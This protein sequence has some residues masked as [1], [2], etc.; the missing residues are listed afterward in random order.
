MPYNLVGGG[1]VKM[2]LEDII[3][4]FNK[5]GLKALS[6]TETHLLTDYFNRLFLYIYS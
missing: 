4:K 6:Q 3:D 2:N 5:Y 1:E